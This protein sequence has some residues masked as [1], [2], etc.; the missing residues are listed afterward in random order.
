MATIAN[1]S[2]SLL[3]LPDGVEI[4]VGQ[5]VETAD[6]Y[7]DNAGVKSWVVDGMAT[8]TVKQAKGSK[9]A[10]AEPVTPTAPAID[11]DLLAQAAE[12]G[13]AADGLDAD[14]VKAAVDAKLAE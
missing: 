14:A 7:A 1:V 10:A 4:P 2:Q 3:V 5:S 8:V 11:A 13:I 6:D 9:K 12:L